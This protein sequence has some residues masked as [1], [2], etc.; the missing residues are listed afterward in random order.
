M[1]RQT[2]YTRAAK[3]YAREIK[4]AERSAKQCG[5]TSPE[6]RQ[7]LEYAQALRQCMIASVPASALAVAS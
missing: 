1:A 5:H 4:R 7:Y 2:N 6:G 3:A